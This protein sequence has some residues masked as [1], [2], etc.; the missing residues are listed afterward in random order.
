MVTFF[1]YSSWKTLNFGKIMTSSC[2][3]GIDF[4]HPNTNSYIYVNIFQNIEIKDTGQ[5]TAFKSL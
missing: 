1:L 5:E 3:Y 2:F 4:L